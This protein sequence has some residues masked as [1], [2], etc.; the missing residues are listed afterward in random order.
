MGYTE[1]QV[2]TLSVDSPDC[3]LPQVIQVI[4]VIEVQPANP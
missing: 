2:L 1:E 3:S 4:Q